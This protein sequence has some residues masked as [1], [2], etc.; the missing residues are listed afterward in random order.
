[1]ATRSV[2]V[3]IPGSQR[4]ALALAVGGHFTWKMWIFQC[5]TPREPTA[6]GPL[7]RQAQ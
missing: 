5:E 6:A 4:V 3:G 1:M 7:A 2:M